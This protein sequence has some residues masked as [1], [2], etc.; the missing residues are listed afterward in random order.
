MLGFNAFVVS[1][2]FF[3]VLINFFPG[4]PGFIIREAPLLIIYIIIIMHFSV[5]GVTTVKNVKIGE[6]E[7][8]IIVLF[9]Y[10]LF[11]AIRQNPLAVG[12]LG[13]KSYIYYAP[14]YFLVL[15]L[16]DTKEK[17]RKLVNIL[18]YSGLLLCF[19]SVIQYTYTQNVMKFL[20]YQ[21][22]DLAY[23]TSMGH[24]KASAT[25]GNPSA[26]AILSGFILLLTIFNHISGNKELK[27]V[28]SYFSLL[29]LGIGFILSF[30]RITFIGVIL[31][32]ILAFLIYK[33][34]MIKH[35]FLFIIFLFLVNLFMN[36]FLFENFLSSFGVGKNIL[37]I[38]SSK[39]R[40]E[41]IFKGLKFFEVKP[42]FGYGLGITDAPSRH[43]ASILKLGY[44]PTDNYY[45]KLLIESGMVGLVLFLL[46]IFFSIFKGFKYYKRIKDNYLKSVCISMI[47]GLLLISFVSIAN[48]ALEL[49]AINCLFWIMMGLISSSF[50]ADKKIIRCS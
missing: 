43:Y 35:V 26:Y 44:F 10:M 23:R 9:I 29:I 19:I 18:F 42:L 40:L 50:L 33:N 24:L 48:T 13:F 28:T 5:S 8:L 46:L 14:L 7:V 27:N 1:L 30:S 36:N 6:K 49:Q 22:G 21:V 15:A 12:L 25:L 32:L 20:N 37:G 34:K 41:I 2:F 45:L 47:F 17:I 31:T 38:N 3:P 11:Q 39:A 4:V 16:F